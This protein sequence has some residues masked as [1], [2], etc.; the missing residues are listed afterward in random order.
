MDEPLGAVSTTTGTCKWWRDEHGY[1]A[2]ATKATAPFDVWCH[3]SAL[4]MEGFR[5]L[6]PGQ[7][8]R[9]QYERADQDSFRYRAIHVWLLSLSGQTPP[10]E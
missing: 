10:K 5:L 6:T 2:I 9:V 7:A 3:F 8:V 4:E 1:G